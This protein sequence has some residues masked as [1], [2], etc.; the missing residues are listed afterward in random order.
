MATWKAEVFENEYLAADATDVHAIVSIEC[1]DAGTAGQSGAA[2]ELIVIDTSG[3]MASPHAK[4]VAAREAAAAA[5]DAITDDTYFAV[6]A[7]NQAARHVYP[8]RSGMVLAGE[9]SRGDAKEA[10]RHL[11]TQGGTAIGSWLQAA[12][13]VFGSVEAA[14]CHAILLT[15]GRDETDA[16]HALVALVQSGFGE[17]QCNA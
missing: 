1:S 7:G 15:D 5:V 14:Q 10:V 12:I 2:A 17:D 9:Q 8:Y 3:S 6:I 11:D 4:I 16:V 13:A